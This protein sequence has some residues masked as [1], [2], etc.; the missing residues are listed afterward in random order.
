M[1]LPPTEIDHDLVRK[2]PG[3]FPPPRGES[4]L[5]RRF[6]NIKIAREGGPRGQPRIDPTGWEREN[7]I[8][9][10]LPGAPRRIYLN[11]KILSVT[12][13]AFEACH[14]LKLG[15]EI[16][17][18]SCFVIRNKR[19]KSFQLSTHSW[20]IAFDINPAQNR[21]TATADSPLIT[22]IPYQWIAALERRGF[23]WGGHFK[24]RKDPMHFQY[25]HAY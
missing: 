20:A 25:A 2:I 18:L 15:Y 10:L 13:D 6:G 8:P 16:K 12:V 17:S 24:G 19:T 7:L 9:V 5:R 1:V 4:E 11:K 21:L 22:D 3:W 14:A 23:L